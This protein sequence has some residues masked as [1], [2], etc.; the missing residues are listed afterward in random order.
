M[1]QRV[2][3]RHAAEEHSTLGH[4][5]GVHNSSTAMPQ[6][7]HLLSSSDATS[8]PQMYHQ[9]TA[10]DTTHPQTNG[11]Q[12]C[13]CASP[14]I[15]SPNRPSSPQIET[16]VRAES[17]LGRRLWTKS[18]AT[19]ACDGGECFLVQVHVYAVHLMTCNG[20]D[21]ALIALMSTRQLNTATTRLP[22]R[23]TSTCTTHSHCSLSIAMHAP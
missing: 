16:I 14:A 20:Q 2:A 19:S 9:C 13:C 12:S 4:F 18:L 23:Q 3:S 8:M 15:P 7:P 5:T 11:K 17:V 1:H 10:N 6:Q 21:W 22:R